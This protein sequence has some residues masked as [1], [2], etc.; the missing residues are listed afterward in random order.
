MSSYYDLRIQGYSVFS[1]RRPIQDEV[2]SL[3]VEGDRLKSSDRAPDLPSECANVHSEDGFVGYGSTVAAIA[4]RL[5]VMGFTP[6]RARA[7]FDRG[8]AI[9]IEHARNYDTPFKSLEEDERAYLEERSKSELERLSQ[10]SF[11]RWTDA[12][13]RLTRDRIRWKNFNL[14]KPAYSRTLDSV[15][16]HILDSDRSAF[17]PPLGF[18]CSDIRFLIRAFLLAVQP[19]D[20]V[21]LDCTDLVSDG[22]FDATDEIV[23]HA[24]TSIIDEARAVDRILVLTEGSSDTK[25]LQRT[26]EVLYPHLREFVSFL[27]HDQFSVSGGAG[28]LLNLLRG[29]AGAGV[30]NRVVALFDNDTAGSVQI[31]RAAAIPLPKNYRILQLPHLTFAELYPTLGPTGLINTDI[32]GSACSI[33]LYLG[34]SALT[35]SS[36]TLMPIQW[37]G[38]EKSLSRYQ[39]ELVDKRLVQQQYLDELDR[40]TADTKSMQLV[41]REIL[42]AF[43]N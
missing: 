33:E 22:H 7:D 13:R 31:A 35:V 38:Y 8:L 17:S 9:E 32:N 4:D 15:E 25:M 23:A 43:H 40:G 21:I 26:L 30:S 41:F 36:D 10:Q 34:I 5:D 20:P 2:L 6:E 19:A 29:F 28:N 18:N 27:D 42:T 16:A 12:I 1:E 11:D 37:T 14:P 24:R 3:F 39:G